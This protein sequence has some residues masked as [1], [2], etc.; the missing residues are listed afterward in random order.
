MISWGWAV[1]SLGVAAEGPRAVMPEQI[2][3]IRHAEKFQGAE[4]RTPFVTNQLTLAGEER[5][6]ALAPFFM[7]NSMLTQYGVPVAV[8]AAKPST[9]Y[10]SIRPMQTALPTA[11]ALGLDLNLHYSLGEEAQAAQEILH[12]SAYEGKN[13]LICWEHCSIPVLAKALGVQDPTHWPDSVFDWVF[14]LHY[15]QG[16]STPAFQI[17]P[18]KLMYGD[19]P[20]VVFSQELQECLQ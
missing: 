1:A 18:Q 2:M 5:A 9:E 8:Y 10:E 6:A 15:P 7:G 12:H 16:S 20:T 14:I 19:A 11:A 13:I 3:I 4:R 17:I